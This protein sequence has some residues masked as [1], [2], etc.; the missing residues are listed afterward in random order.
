MQGIDVLVRV[1]EGMSRSH[2]PR[3]ARAMLNDLA[4]EGRAAWQEEMRQ[5]LTLRNE[6]TSRRALVEPARSYSLSQMA[7]RLGH[8]EPYMADLEDGGV[9]PAAKRYRPIPTEIAAGQSFGSLRGGRML[10]VRTRYNIM[11]I[12]KITT[13]SGSRPRKAQNARNIKGAL[14]SGRRL[15]LLD[16]GRRKGIY[17]VKGSKRKPT[18]EKVYDLTRRKTRIPKIPTLDRA[19]DNVLRSAPKIGLAHLERELARAKGNT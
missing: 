11:K 1:L 15:T 2:V 12:G 19:V 14:R 17:R 7:A 6:F 13:T 16:L 18:I 3:A 5:S 8:T 10:A 4:F 9:E